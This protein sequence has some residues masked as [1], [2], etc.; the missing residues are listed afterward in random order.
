MDSS[1]STQ[2]D[3][4]VPPKNTS[5]C[6]AGC[7]QRPSMSRTTLQKLECLRVSAHTY[8]GVVPNA[9]K[10]RPTASKDAVSTLGACLYTL[11]VVRAGSAT[12]FRKSR[13]PLLPD[14]VDPSV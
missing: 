3:K 13:S 1:R 7:G 12:P 9:S 5:R 4:S 8:K 14:Q 6:G 2:L 11:L 10:P